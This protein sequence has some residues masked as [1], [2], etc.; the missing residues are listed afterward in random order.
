MKTVR[1][2][3]AAAAALMLVGTA[4]A[5]GPTPGAWTVTGSVS[6]DSPVS[7][8]LHGGT[9]TGNLPLTA[10][11]PAL[12]AGTVGRLEIGS[13]SFRDVYGSTDAAFTLEAARGLTTSDELFGAVTY[14]KSEASR[15]Q[16]GDA[17]VTGGPLTGARLPVFGQFG[18]YESYA[19]EAGYRRYFNDGGS[20]RPYV[21]G[22]AG[23]VTTDEIR[24][25]FTV[26]GA[27]I[28][29][30]NVRFYDGG[31]SY[32]VGADLGAAYAV[33][34]RFSLAAEVGVRYRSDLKDDDADIGGLGLGSINDEGARV[35]VPVS[36]R[37]TL[38]F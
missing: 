30:N 29:L 26:P 28:A 36:L 3:A 9:T 35:S 34:D 33:S 19:F 23:V 7:G 27:G 4:Q 14:L 1:F 31:T 32:T 24:G 15:L 13:R 12:P 2:F 8:D 17:V 21:A 25:T 16:V 37:G 5:T 11:N 10:L 22:R 20:F 18:D 38:K 6:A